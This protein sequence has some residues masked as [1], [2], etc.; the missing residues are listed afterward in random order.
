M[1][2]QELT[3]EIIEEALLEMSKNQERKYYAVTGL[4]GFLNYEKQILLGIDLPI[5]IVEEKIK[6]VEE[7]ILK[8]MKEKGHKNFMCEIIDA[9][10]KNTTW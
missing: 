5:N 9:Y 1:K 10:V 8:E 3:L 6:K 7:D 2:Y 4:K